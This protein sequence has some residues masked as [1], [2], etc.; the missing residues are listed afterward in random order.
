[1]TSLEVQSKKCGWLHLA[2]MLTRADWWQLPA[3]LTVL[4]QEPCTVHRYLPWCLKVYVHLFLSPRAKRLQA[5]HMSKETR[6]D[7][8]GHA[9]LGEKVCLDPEPLPTP[10]YSVPLLTSA[11]WSARHTE[12]LLS[13]KEAAE[14]LHL[15]RVKAEPLL[16]LRG[17]VTWK[18]VQIEHCSSMNPVPSVVL[19]EALN[20]RGQPALLH[21]H[22]CHGN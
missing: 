1:M 11:P 21:R 10:N 2:L 4:T 17:R 19:I 3:C 22:I 9:V 14:W 7:E 18:S 15:D 5:L 13:P 6:P 20:A 12:Q 8:R 16:R